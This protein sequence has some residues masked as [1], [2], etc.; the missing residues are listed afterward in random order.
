M[1]VE[2]TFVSALVGEPGGRRAEATAGEEA[3]DITHGDP[4]RAREGWCGEL[5]IR[6]EW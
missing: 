5:L 2:E 1:A 4:R 6:N 3:I